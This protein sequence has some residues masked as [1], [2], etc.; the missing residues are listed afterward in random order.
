MP[1]SCPR[2]LIQLQRELWK[3]AAM[4]RMDRPEVPGGIAPHKSAGMCSIRK[5]VTRLLRCSRP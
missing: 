5:A 2:V 4:A 1:N 3:C